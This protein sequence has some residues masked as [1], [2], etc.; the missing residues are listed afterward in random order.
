MKKPGTIAMLF[1]L[2]APGQTKPDPLVRAHLPMNTSPLRSNPFFR[3]SLMGAVLTGSLAFAG[4]SQAA[5]SFNFE[6]AD[7]AGTGFLDPTFGAARQ[8]ALVEAGNRFS[9]LFG[10]YFTNS[11]V[12]TFTATANNTG[13]AY[14]GSAQESST[15][16]GDG[17]VVRNKII[18]GVDLNASAADGY[19]NYNFDGA[20]FILDPNAIVDFN[21]GEIDFLS[22]TYHEFTHALGWGSNI[23]SDGTAVNGFSKWDQFLTTSGGI[24]L[25]NP[26]T[27]LVNTA[28]YFDSAANGGTFSGANAIAAWGSPVPTNVSP[29]I[30]HLNQDAFS[31]PQVPV[32]ALMRGTGQPPDLTVPRDY[33][34]AE[35]GILTD[36]GYTAVPE[37]SSAL[38]GA[39][40]AMLV[41]TKRRRSC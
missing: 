16:F 38:L 14:A 37:T 24:S 15:G 26:N 11:A 4:I 32:N 33:N 28:A 18:S 30:S 7:P 1:P 3:R 25:V 31:T 17:E 13:L 20:T 41:M 5:L 10:T 23:A 12:L 19:V 6:Y 9:A 39:F 22:V 21:A 40:G 27:M 29:D 35:V 2:P 8:A 34:A 36:L